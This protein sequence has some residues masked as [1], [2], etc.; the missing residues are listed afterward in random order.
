MLAFVDDGRPGTAAESTYR[1]MVCR[2]VPSDARP[3]KR[4]GPC[5]DPE[6]FLH[7]KIARTLE[8]SR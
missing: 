4:P 1:I 2:T 3:A 7:T 8:I 5:Q 6:V